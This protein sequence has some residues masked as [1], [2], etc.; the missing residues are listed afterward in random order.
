M[1]AFKH[2]IFFSL[3]LI[4]TLVFSQ[5]WKLSR[6]EYLY[7]I[8][9]VNSFGDIGGASN[10]DAS[11]FV[12]LDIAYSRPV[13]AIGYR[14]K[15]YERFAIKANL[16]YANIHGSDVKSINESRD[17]SFTTN[18]FEL[19]GHIEYHI[20][21]ETHMVTYNNMS[22]RG[23]LHKFNRGI[24]LYVFAGIGGTYFKPKALDSFAEGPRS[25][26]FVDNKNLALVFPIGLGF[27]YPLTSAT[28]IGFELGGRFTT[29]DFI[30]GFSS[31]SSNS[32]DVYYFT[33]I[34]VS[35]KIKK[36]SRRKGYRF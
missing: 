36:I 3:L 1:K 12:D 18:M 13:L 35:T 2:I 20:T 21:K 31:E 14:Y 32:K 28:Y 17:F 27:K 10:A 30:D 7:G 23:K 19:N 33:V 9:I 11:S 22:M 26:E 29:T 16:T 15:L 8:G 4:P 6:S 25:V 34:N 5:K 24:N